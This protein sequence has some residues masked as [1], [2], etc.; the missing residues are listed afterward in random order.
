MGVATV[1]DRQML[2]EVALAYCCS[3]LA[4]LA[5]Q[6]DLIPAQSNCYCWQLAISVFYL[7]SVSLPSAYFLRVSATLAKCEANKKGKKELQW[8]LNIII[9]PPD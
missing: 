8:S 5:P 7:Q 6:T 9:E 2:I 3:L 1:I 4:K